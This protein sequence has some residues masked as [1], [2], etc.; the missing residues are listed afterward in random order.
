M[1]EDASDRSAGS[2][3]DSFS[4]LSTDGLTNSFVGSTAQVCVVTRD[5]MTTH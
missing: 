1:E 5:F 4:A 2:L 3:T